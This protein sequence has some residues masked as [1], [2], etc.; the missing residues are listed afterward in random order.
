MTSHVHMYHTEVIVPIVN[1]EAYDEERIDAHTG[2]TM[3][4]YRLI[5]L[6]RIALH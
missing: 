2:H 4:F 1:A 3:E 5:C 6:A